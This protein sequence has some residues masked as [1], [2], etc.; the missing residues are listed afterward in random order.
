MTTDGA[1]VEGNVVG[2]KRLRSA[3]ACRRF[4]TPQRAL[5]LESA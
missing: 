5:A 4:T 1:T 2:A 3:A